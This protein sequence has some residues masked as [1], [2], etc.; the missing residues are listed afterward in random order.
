MSQ[1]QE[2]MIR[3]KSDMRTSFTAGCVAALQLASDRENEHRIL[4]PPV[5][6][7]DSPGRRLS[8]Q[9]SSSPILSSTLKR[10]R[11]A[12]C[13]TPPGSPPI[14]PC[15]AGKL[16]L[17]PRRSS[18]VDPH[19]FSLLP[20]LSIAT[21]AALRAALE[22]KTSP[23]PQSFACRRLDH[24]DLMDSSPVRRASPPS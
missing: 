2:E 17:P 24:S 4:S 22:E 19:R 13:V 1:P 10:K 3:R 16:A 20:P 8:P 18:D 6:E 7:L 5:D 21:G 12:S 11:T 23:I 15:D 9:L 14:H